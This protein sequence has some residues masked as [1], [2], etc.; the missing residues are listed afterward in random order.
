[1][2]ITRRLA[3]TTTIALLTFTAATAP[4]AADGK[5]TAR[6]LFEDEVWVIG[7]KPL[8]QPV[9]AGQSVR[10]RFPVGE[11]EIVADEIDVGLKIGDAK[12]VLE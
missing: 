12:V 2:T 4:A 11:L 8:L 9:A 5:A 10:V 7:A 1:M 3:R 6:P